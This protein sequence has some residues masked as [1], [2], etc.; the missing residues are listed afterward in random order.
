MA[1]FYPMDKRMY[2]TIWNETGLAHEDKE[3]QKVRTEFVNRVS[4]EV[5][6]QLLDCLLDDGVLNDGEKESILEENHSRADKARQL[7]DK[8]KKKGAEASKRMIAHLQ[9]KDKTLY[10]V[11]GLSGGQPAQPAPAAPAA[12]L[13]PAA[14]AALAAPPPSTVREF[15]MS[16]KDDPKIYP[17]TESSFKSR[18]ALLIT[19]IEFTEEKMKRRGAE[20]DEENME[21]LL[22]SLGYE[23]VKF[24]NLTGQA[25][26]DAVIYFTKHPK[27]KQADSVFVVIMS[28]GQ[29]GKILGVEW[30]EGKPD[31]FPINNIFKH[32][33]SKSCPALIDKP[34]VIIIQAC[35]GGERGSVLVSDSPNTADDVQQPQDFEEDKIQFVHQE[36]DFISLLSCTP[37][38]VS[39]RRPDR[40]SILIQYIVEVFTL[41][42]YQEHIYELFQ[43]V[44]QHVERF[45]SCDKLQMPTIDRC[46]LIKNFYIFQGLLNSSR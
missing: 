8:V 13:A 46:T 30:K 41:E 22:S 4:T 23:V 27:L 25:I 3:L 33:G 42:S 32:L 38:T 15:W 9:D 26:D 40:G 2:Y 34:K 10:G 7:I 6:K 43:K 5:I 18:V 24:T 36:K 12:P 29:L 45:R 37:D 35:R 39:Y 44:M 14:P 17:V 16:K 20:K 19:N 1:T 21:K 11:L 28:H 31:E